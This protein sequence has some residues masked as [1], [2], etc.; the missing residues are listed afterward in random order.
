MKI[1]FEKLNEQAVVPTR[2]HPEDAGLDFVTFYHTTIPAHG[3]A[4][5][6]TGLRCKIED[7]NFFMLIKDRSSMALEGLHVLAG[8]VD[9]GYRGEI[10]I[11]LYNTSDH[12]I[13]LSEGTKIAQGIIL[14][15]EYPEIEEGTVDVKETARQDGGFGSTGEKV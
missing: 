5:I 7:R 11:I 4:I 14:P 2:A 12:D 15:V 10:K 1:I 8:V 13:E 6:S 3:R 9:N